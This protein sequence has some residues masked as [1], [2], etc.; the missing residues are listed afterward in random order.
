M[1][2]QKTKEAI[3]VG[4]ADV[5]KLHCAETGTHL[6]R[7]SEYSYI[8]AKKCRIIDK[9]KQYITDN[10]LTDI[11][12][13]SSIHDLGKIS[14][15]DDV[16]HKPGSLT[17]EEYELIKT[18][19]I[20]GLSPLTA[21]KNKLQDDQ[22]FMMAENIIKCH[23]EKWDGTGYPCGLKE[24]RIPL[25]ARIVSI[26]DVYDALTTE[27]CYKKAISHEDALVEIFNE[28]GR[29]FDPEITDLFLRDAGEFNLIRKIIETQY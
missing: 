6:R 22:Y 9:Y 20:Q 29:Q 23:H 16:L 4:L 1:S 15:P 27:R 21:A 24:D 25:S 26:V 14:I 13:S 8:L 10:Y 7:I 2:E 28:R 5:V 3:I 18:H 19:T 17:K 11:H 12:I